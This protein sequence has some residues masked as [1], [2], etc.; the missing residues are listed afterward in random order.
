VTGALLVP[1]FPVLVDIADLVDQLVDSA[2]YSLRRAP[3]YYQQRLNPDYFA[4]I[5]DDGDRL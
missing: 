2:S 3:A 5:S 4:D 1:R